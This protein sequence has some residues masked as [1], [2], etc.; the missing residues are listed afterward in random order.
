M[1]FR[2]GQH[3]RAFARV[4]MGQIMNAKR[5]TR[6]LATAAA[7]A[8]AAALLPS[9]SA[10]A[11]PSFLIFGTCR[12][13]YTYN[14]TD[15]WIWVTLYDTA[16]VTH[17]DWGWVGPHSDRA[18]SGGGGPPGSSYMC[19][20]VYFARAEVKAKGPFNTPNIF[21]TTVEVD[22]Q[23][24]GGGK[25]RACLTTNNNGGSY[26]WVYT[27]DCIESTD[28]NNAGGL[29]AA[30][31][32]SVAR[33][34][35]VNAAPLKPTPYPHPAVIRLAAGSVQAPFGPTSAVHH[36]NITV[37]GKKQPPVFASLGKWTTT[38]PEIIEI[39]DNTGAFRVLKGGTG[40]MTWT[41]ADK[42]YDTTIHA[43]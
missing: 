41:Y 32:P 17:M 1:P 31:G 38:T 39:V 33:V 40:T 22:P 36:I 8:L 42:K 34:A 29:N 6:H 4:N 13:I 12:K 3:V 26:F 19:G 24:S 23:T 43:P 20:I 14:A 16:K 28:P 25:N 10:L 30:R 7:L 27:D 15:H 2:A 35:A 9:R 37:D 18:W 11:N 21:D 5:S